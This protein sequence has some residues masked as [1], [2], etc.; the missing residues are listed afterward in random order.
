M[1]QMEKMKESHE[2]EIMSME[3]AYQNKFKERHGR[4]TAATIMWK[5]GNGSR[6]D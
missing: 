5:I 6:E 3:N 1:I 2:L 4:E